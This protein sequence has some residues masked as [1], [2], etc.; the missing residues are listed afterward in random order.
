MIRLA[1]FQSPGI[2]SLDCADSLLRLVPKPDSSADYQTGE[3]LI[4]YR[5][6][7]STVQIVALRLCGFDATIYP[8]P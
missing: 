1:P 7:L 5:L 8:R 4:Q 2:L 3:H 6:P